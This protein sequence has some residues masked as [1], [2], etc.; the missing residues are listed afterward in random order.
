MD[1]AA[2]TLDGVDAP[3]LSLRG[4]RVAPAAAVVQDGR[5]DIGELVGSGGQ[6]DVYRVYDRELRRHMVM[7]VIGPDGASDPIALARFVQEAQ[8]T[9]QLQHPNIVPVHEIGTLTSGNRY[10]T[11][12]EVRGRTLQSVIDAVHAASGD[13]WG[14]EPGGFGFRR[15]I[16]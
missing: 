14:V 16:D 15:L 9:A 10:Y 12:A 5:Y 1:D 3:T 13:E 6:G 11:M 8:I 2:P 7:K 4:H